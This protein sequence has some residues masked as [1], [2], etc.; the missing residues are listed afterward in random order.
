[1]II[2][3]YRQSSVLDETSSA[4]TARRNVSHNPVFLKEFVCVLSWSC[5]NSHLVLGREGVVISFNG[6]GGLFE[7]SVEVW[8]S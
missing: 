2:A 8:S 6:F 5:E 7:D 3:N 4:K 1:M